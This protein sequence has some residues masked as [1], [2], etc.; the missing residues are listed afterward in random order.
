MSGI[1]VL[2]SLNGKLSGI[3]SLSGTIKE[4]ERYNAYTGDYEVVPQAFQSQTLE[5]ANKL[6]QKNIIIGEIPYFE[7]GNDSNGVTA[8]IAK[9][10]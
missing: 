9:G 10:D 7:T 6:L 8:Y 3:G 1:Q 2:D 5:T 4:A